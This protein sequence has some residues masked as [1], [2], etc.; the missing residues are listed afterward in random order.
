MAGVRQP[1][2]GDVLDDRGSGTLTQQFEQVL[3]VR[4]RAFGDAPNR[5]VLLV[6]D[7]AGEAEAIGVGYD[8]VAESDAMN[9]TRDS[10]LETG[11]L[12]GLHRRGAALVPAPESAPEPTRLP[13]LAC[14]AAGS[15]CGQLSAR[16]SRASSG[17]TLS[18]S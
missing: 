7:P 2:F 3:Q 8:V 5:T 17:F 15:M 18:S 16:T 11:H 1:L 9:A 4:A 12:D 14:V 13:G 10:G 6:G